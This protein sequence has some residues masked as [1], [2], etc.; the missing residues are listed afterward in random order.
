LNALIFC[1][2]G[3]WRSRLSILSCGDKRDRVNSRR[4][5]WS[6]KTT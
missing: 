4:P 2:V 5:F 3:I 1:I 6:P